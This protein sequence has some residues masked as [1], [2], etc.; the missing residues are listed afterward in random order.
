MIDRDQCDMLIGADNIHLL[1]TMDEPSAHR[2]SG[3]LHARHSPVG[4]IISGCIPE[5]KEHFQLIKD[6][7][8]KN[9]PWEHEFDKQT[10]DEE[11]TI[12]NDDRFA[13]EIVE[14]MIKRVDQ[15]KFQIAMPFRHINPNMPNNRQQAETR[16]YR[17]WSMFC[18]NAELRTSRK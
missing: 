15:Y 16:L 2:V 18:H 17:Q 7:P 5:I 14:R 3:S 1:G 11:L 6:E 13:M 4:W 12:S 8:L 9:N 10:D